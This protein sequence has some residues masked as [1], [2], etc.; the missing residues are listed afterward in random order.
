[1]QPASGSDSDL[2]LA[3]ASSAARIRR[4]RTEDTL[5]DAIPRPFIGHLVFYCL[6]EDVNQPAIFGL[7]LRPDGFLGLSADRQALREALAL[8]CPLQDSGDSL[9]L[10][11]V[12]LALRFQ[13]L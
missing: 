2:V 10:S 1:A 8:L 3:V 13:V 6:D 4:Y 7:R 9:H 11:Y 12:E 5:P